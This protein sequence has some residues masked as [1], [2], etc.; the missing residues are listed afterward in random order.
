MEKQE[1]FININDVRYACISKYNFTVNNFDK[2][3]EI[4]KSHADNDI[5][6][7]NIKFYNE[8]NEEFIKAIKPVVND[9]DALTEEG[10]V[11]LFLDLTGDDDNEKYGYFEKRPCGDYMYRA[12]IKGVKDDAFD[13][14]NNLNILGIIDRHAVEIGDLFISKY[15]LFTKEELAKCC[16]SMR[17]IVN[18]EEFL[19]YINFEFDRRID[20]E[21]R[22]MLRKNIDSVVKAVAK[23]FP[24]RE[25]LNDEH[26]E[27]ILMKMFLSNDMYQKFK[28]EKAMEY[29]CRYPNPDAMFEE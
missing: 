3:M 28:D 21:I 17:K 23:A 24:E 26:V 19:A 29:F 11:M 22:N 13:Y 8:F 4:I 7:E 12:S 9:A 27:D 5:N 10:K 16:V 1:N 25:I 14:I 2:T 6:M 18:L 15:G 20:D